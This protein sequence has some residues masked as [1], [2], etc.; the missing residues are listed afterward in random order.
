MYACRKVEQ[1]EVRE[2][3]GFGPT[4]HVLGG[5]AD[6]GAG[7]VRVFAAH[8]FV[9]EDLCIEGWTNAGEIYAI[10]PKAELQ[11]TLCDVE[12]KPNGAV[13]WER[14]HVIQWKGQLPLGPAVTAEN[15][16]RS[17]T[18]LAACHTEI[19]ELRSVIVGGEACHLLKVVGIK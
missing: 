10:S 16:E 6:I 13:V 9:R 2:G 3:R 18:V 14:D 7:K 12:A 17:L 8:P 19:V 11:N 1:T 4:G 15:I 5:H